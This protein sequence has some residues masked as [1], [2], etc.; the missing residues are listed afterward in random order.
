VDALNV[1]GLA[2]HKR[3]GF[4]SADLVRHRNSTPG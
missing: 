2:A 1:G 4:R 3:F